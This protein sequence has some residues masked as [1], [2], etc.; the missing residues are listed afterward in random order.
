M[1]SSAARNNP[2]ACDPPKSVNLKC[3]PIVDP[4]V[5]PTRSISY[6]CAKRQPMQIVNLE[7]S[8]IKPYPGNAKIHTDHQVAQIAESI[9]LFGFNDPVAVDENNQLIE[10]EGRWLAA[11]RLGLKEIPA[12]RLAHLSERQKRA[13]ILAHNKLTLNTGYDFEKLSE[14]V[15]RLVDEDFDIDV[16]GFDEQEID[17]ML[18]GDGGILPDDSIHVKAH[19]RSGKLTR[20]EKEA[21]I[22]V[23][24]RGEVW[25]LGEHRLEV[26][27]GNGHCDSIILH[28]QKLSK[29]KAVRE[30]DGAEYDEINE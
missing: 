1:E 17:A 24:Q 26:G 20:K 12:I 19:E 5:V 21:A 16:L 8:K 30:S 25:V 18:Q 23:C 3:Q 11:H 27:E 15:S 22:P 9:S 13:Y 7:H 14:E 4:P 6:F 2:G 10:G 28:W 29:Q